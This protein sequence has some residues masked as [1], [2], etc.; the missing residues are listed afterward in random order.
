MVFNYD[1]ILGELFKLNREINFSLASSNVMVSG[2][3]QWVNNNLKG[4][5]TN[6]Q[7]CQKVDNSLEALFVLLLDGLKVS[8]QTSNSAKLWL[9]MVQ[10]TLVKLQSHQM[11]SRGSCG[12]SCRVSCTV[13]PVYFHVKCHITIPVECHIPV[14]VLSKVFCRMFS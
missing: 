3:H 14:T 7:Y 11:C 12:V 2:E 1:C 8:N 6:V 5:V 9:G 13:F 4:G 10:L